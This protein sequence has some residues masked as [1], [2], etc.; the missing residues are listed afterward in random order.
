MTDDGLSATA[1]GL[2]R[3]S[4]RLA[5]RLRAE[6]PV[7]AVSG[8]GI[9][10]LGHL[11]RRG[12][13]TAGELAEAE[14][15][16]PQSLTRALAALESGGLIVRSRPPGDRRRHHIGITEAGARALGDHVREV[17][18]WLAREMARTLT[19]AECRMLRIAADLL[20]R[21]LDEAGPA[22]SGRRGG[23]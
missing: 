20:D 8:L 16:Q 7:H 19:P 11:Y 5:R 1:A 13:M 12:P 10:L 22:A 21:V 17:D 18:D 9:S 4:T 6:R 23:E 14:R 15:L 3:A 2:R